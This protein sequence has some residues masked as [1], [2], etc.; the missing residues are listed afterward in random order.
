MVICM[1]EDFPCFG[2][3]REVSQ[4]EVGLLSVQ[5]NFPRKDRVVGQIHQVAEEI[6]QSR[7]ILLHMPS[8]SLVKTHQVAWVT[9]HAQQQYKEN[10]PGGWRRFK[11][12]EEEDQLGVVKEN[13]Y[14]R[15]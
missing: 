7:D 8:S 11:Q 4:G 1:E 9:A 2:G 13:G 14:K 6:P 10:T 15:K 12:G 5:G 3:A